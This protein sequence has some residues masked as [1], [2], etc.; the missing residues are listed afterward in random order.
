[1]ALLSSFHFSEDELEKTFDNNIVRIVPKKDGVLEK[2]NSKRY[3]YLVEKNNFIPH[4][5]GNNVK[6]FT[7]D[8][9]T[10]IDVIKIKNVY[11]EYFASSK[12]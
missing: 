5:K 9:V 6:Y 2:M 7:Q 1:M 4:E 11:E 10:I 12:I 3:L 8:P